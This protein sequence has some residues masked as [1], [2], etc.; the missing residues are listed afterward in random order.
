MKSRDPLP[1]LYGSVFIR[2]SRTHLKI[3]SRLK[4]QIKSEFLKDTN[5]SEP[6]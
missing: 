6:I 1:Y 5:S 3:P 4:Y 2:G